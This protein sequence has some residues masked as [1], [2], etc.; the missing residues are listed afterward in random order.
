MSDL[1]LIALL[2]ER[3][4]TERFARAM[5]YIQALNA[6]MEKLNEGR[7]LEGEVPIGEDP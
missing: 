7:F 3:L 5:D 1:E 2:M 4:D 6:E